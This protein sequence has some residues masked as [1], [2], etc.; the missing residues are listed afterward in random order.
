[1]ERME[2][3][4]QDQMDAEM[5][6][7]AE[8]DCRAPN[9]SDS[10]WKPDYNVTPRRVVCAANRDRATGVIICGARHW[11]KLMRGQV[12]AMGLAYHGWDDGFVDQFGDFMDRKEAWLVA[13]DQ[14]KIRR[15]VGPEG[16]LFSE[17][18]Y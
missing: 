17:N 10:D 12:E 8:G 11:D 1:M 13:V 7:N 6:R 9:C 16:T 14:E 4:M 2:S 3:Q 5:A 15:T 18:L